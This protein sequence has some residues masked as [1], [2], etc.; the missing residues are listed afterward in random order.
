MMRSHPDA[1][2][3]ARPARA[4]VLEIGRAA[5]TSGPRKIATRRTSPTNA[6]GTPTK[7]RPIGPRNPLDCQSLQRSAGG[8]PAT[9]VTPA[10]VAPRA[11]WR[12]GN[13]SKSIQNLIP[14]AASVSNATH[15]AVAITNFPHDANANFAPAAPGRRQS[16]ATINSAS[17][18]SRP[19]PTLAAPTSTS[20]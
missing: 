4:K 9:S 17:P 1:P 19:T 14:P 16:G 5:C 12:Y 10:R 7:I 11:K 3:D 20:S 13:S 15:T 8:G 18:T 2:T 6:A